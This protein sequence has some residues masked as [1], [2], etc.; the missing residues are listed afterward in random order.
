[1][2]KA[3]WSDFNSNFEYAFKR[4]FIELVEIA[5]YVY[6]D[7]LCSSFLGQLS[8][9]SVKK[10]LCTNFVKK[11]NDIKRYR[12]ISHHFKFAPEVESGIIV[13]LRL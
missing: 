7:R 8:E 5:N 6:N 10:K 2:F 12:V 13:I 11:T 3:A 4:L 1:M 9:I